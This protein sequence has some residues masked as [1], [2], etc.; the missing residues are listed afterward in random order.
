MAVLEAGVHLVE[1]AV[2]E[3]EAA[4]WLQEEAAA[5]ALG[6][7]NLAMVEEGGDHRV[8]PG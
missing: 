8:D 4:S 2:E 5:A 1:V 3:E 7:Q 6:L